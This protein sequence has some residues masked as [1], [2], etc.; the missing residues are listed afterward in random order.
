MERIVFFER[1]D[2]W[3]TLL[4]GQRGCSSDRFT[5]RRACLD[6]GA[7]YHVEFNP[8]MKTGTCN[9]CSGSIYYRS[10]GQEETTRE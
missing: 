9:E 4:S 5:G 6:C 3:S 10:D 7:N 8:S 1:V 2:H